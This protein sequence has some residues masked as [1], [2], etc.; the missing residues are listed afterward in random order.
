MVTLNSR[1]PRTPRNVKPL[2]C[3]RKFA[4]NNFTACINHRD[5]G[6]ASKVEWLEVCTNDIFL[7]GPSFCTWTELQQVYLRNKGMPAGTVEYKR[8]GLP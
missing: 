3:T 6:H 4:V 7:R 2:F 1:I 8:M 5:G